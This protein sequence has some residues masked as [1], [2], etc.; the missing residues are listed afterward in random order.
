MIVIG[1]INSC[2]SNKIVID[3]IPFAVN[4]RS[5]EVPNES[6]HHLLVK[7]RQY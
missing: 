7:N 5:V 1:Y 2:K 3:E 4:I 6:D